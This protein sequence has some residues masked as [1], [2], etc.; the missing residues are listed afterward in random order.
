MSMCAGVAQSPH[1]AIPWDHAARNRVSSHAARTDQRV[2]GRQRCQGTPRGLRAGQRGPGHC[3]GNRDPWLGWGWRGALGALSRLET[4]AMQG[5]DS[6]EPQLSWVG[7][8]LRSQA[9]VVESVLG[10][11]WSRAMSQCREAMGQQPLPR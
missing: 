10:E 6:W 3:W 4:D 9:L 5:S 8:S 11:P 1:G 7:G 2:Q